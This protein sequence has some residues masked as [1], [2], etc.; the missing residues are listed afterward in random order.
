MPS[1]HKLIT[2]IV[3]NHASGDG[4]KP[5]PNKDAR[6]QT[7]MRVEQELDERFVQLPCTW[8]NEDDLELYESFIVY[9]AL[10]ARGQTKMRFVRELDER[11]E[12]VRRRYMLIN[13]LRLKGLSGISFSLPHKSDKVYAGLSVV[14]SVCRF[15]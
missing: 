14:T 6:G 5:V 7:K 3:T 10:L 1:S 8:S 12:I 4:L 13:L 15:S 9:R 11:I 2:W